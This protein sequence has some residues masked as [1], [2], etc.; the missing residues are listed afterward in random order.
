MK[1]YLLLGLLVFI[2]LLSKAEVPDGAYFFQNGQGYDVNGVQTFFCLG[3]LSQTCYTVEGDFAFMRDLSTKIDQLQNSVNQLQNTV[4]NLQTTLQTPTQAPVVSG[5]PT[6]IDTVP[7]KILSGV[8]TNLLQTSS[9]STSFD[10]CGYG[11]NGYVDLKRFYDYHIGSDNKYGISIGTNKPTIAKFSF[12]LVDEP[13]VLTY[14]DSNLDTVH[15]IWYTDVPLSPDT[16]YKV[17]I[18][19]TDVN[20]NQVNYGDNASLIASWK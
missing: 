15:N 4:N 20:G 13:S 11:C 17:I 16:K 7:L 12:Y 19:V 3:T 10:P 2:P 5:S 14:V 9:A 18:Q 1:K 8:I 6:I